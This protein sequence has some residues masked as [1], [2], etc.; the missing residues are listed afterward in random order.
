LGE[1]SRE[2]ET[3]V[4]GSKFFLHA[5]RKFLILGCLRG[6]NLAGPGQ[7]PENKEF[8]D[9]IFAFNRLAALREELRKLGVSVRSGERGSMF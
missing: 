9:K 4:R 2:W 7:N 5:K 6:V 3:R 8:I 1:G